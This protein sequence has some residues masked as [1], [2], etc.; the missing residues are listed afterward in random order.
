MSKRHRRNARNCSGPASLQASETCHGSYHGGPEYVVGKPA[1]FRSGRGMAKAGD[2]RVAAN[3]PVKV[4]V[5]NGFAVE[6]EASKG[7]NPP[8]CPYPEHRGDASGP[9]RTERTD[10]SVTDADTMEVQISTD[11][12]CLRNPGGPGGW[13]AVLSVS[14]HGDLCRREI[15]DCDPG[16][17]TNNRMEL[18]AVIQGLQLLTRDCHVRLRTDSRYVERGLVKIQKWEQEGWPAKL[19]N[20]DLWHELAEAAR[21]HTIKCSFVKGHSGDA[22]NERCDTLA[23]RAAKERTSWDERFPPVP[24]A[25]PSALNTERVSVRLVNH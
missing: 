8:G 2:P 10:Q 7:G 13:A 16:P 21:H 1:R 20:E 19:P 12:S 25:R 9:A 17:T 3:G 23:R 5:K 14:H 11:G 4:I 22:D 24:T 15:A 6:P 18:T